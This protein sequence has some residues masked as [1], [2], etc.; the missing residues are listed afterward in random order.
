MHDDA[1]DRDGSAP[2]QHEQVAHEQVPHER[3]TLAMLP[4]PRDPFEEV[5]RFAYG[6]DGYARFGTRLCGEMANRA[7]DH[8]LQQ[9]HV[10]DWLHNDLDRLRACVW[11]EARRWI[12]LKR[13]PD[14]RSLIYVH[15]LVDAIAD[16]IEARARPEAVPAVDPRPDRP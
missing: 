13:E 7:M 9:G 12:V 8:V 2:H 1:G 15:R 10:P 11:F 16:A 3:L 5:V 4:H 14:T 6:Y